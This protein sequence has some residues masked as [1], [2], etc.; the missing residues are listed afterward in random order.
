[1]LANAPEGSGACV[2]VCALKL[3]KLAWALACS[4]LLLLVGCDDSSMNSTATSASSTLPSP[5]SKNTATLSWEAPTTDTNGAPLTN[6]S[7]YVIY[8]G[9]SASDLSQ[10]IQVTSVGIQTY[11]VDN[12]APGTWYF[13]IQAVTTSG[14]VSALSD[15]V[16][17]TIS[18]G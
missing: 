16:S 9:E 14:A 6:L 17:T 4:S 1:M 13:A 12:L 10:T 7:G 2:E 8:F 11:V 15:V 18:T 5:A 3:Q